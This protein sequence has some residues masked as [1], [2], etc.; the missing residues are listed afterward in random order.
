MYE[1]GKI[2]KW[3]DSKEAAEETQHL[4]GTLTKVTRGPFMAERADGRVLP[5]YI[6]DSCST[7]GEPIFALEGDLLEVATSSIQKPQ[8]LHKRRAPIFVRWAALRKASWY[9]MR[10]L[11]ESGGFKPLDAIGFIAWPAFIYLIA[12][13]IE[14]D[15]RKE[16][17]QGKAFEK[18]KE[19]VLMSKQDRDGND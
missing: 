9:W 18:F 12:R 16:E 8:Q 15:M 11:K 2:Y 4:P 13:E 3:R 5:A 7:F 6:T 10:A 1:I 17:A 14:E 19:R